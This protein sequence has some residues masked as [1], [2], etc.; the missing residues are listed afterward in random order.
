MVTED[1][2]ASSMDAANVEEMLKRSA[3]PSTMSKYSRL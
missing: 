2:D 1:D 3:K